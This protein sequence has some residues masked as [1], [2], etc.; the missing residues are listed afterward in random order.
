M[1]GAYDIPAEASNTSFLQKHLSSEIMLTFS[2]SLP[3]SG[4]SP[5]LRGRAKL[6]SCS[7]GALTI[8]YCNAILKGGKVQ[9]LSIFGVFCNIL[10]HIG[11]YWRTMAYDGVRWRESPIENVVSL[12][13]G[14]GEASP[15][16]FR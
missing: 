6:L 7:G 12:H 5:Y 1:T 3:P 8:T 2:Y 9:Y 4:D 13:H 14:T 15:L 10:E 11:A 16:G